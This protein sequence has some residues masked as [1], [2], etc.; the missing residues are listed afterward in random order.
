MNVGAEFVFPRY[1]LWAKAIM[2]L[3]LG[4]L[5]VFFATMTV[6]VSHDS[7]LSCAPGG[8][9]THVER[10]PFGIER[11]AP[12]AKVASA[13]VEWSTGGRVQALKLVLTHEDGSFTDYQGVG[14]NGERAERTA[15]AINAYL[16]DPARGATFA[17]REGS[18]PL[19]VFLAL[20]TLGAL[21]LV[22]SFFARVRLRRPAQRVQVRIGRWPAPLREF[23]MEP[24]EFTVRSIINPTDGTVRFAVESGEHDLGMIFLSE[25]RARARAAT[26]NA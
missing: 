5:G 6:L 7:E 18:M 21:A 10:Y 16:H 24:I 1:G 25:A 8:T 22:P 12:V 13:G 11:R 14:T 19:A 4:G 23:E 17:L 3:V 2:T 15:K 20:L 9:C 26:L